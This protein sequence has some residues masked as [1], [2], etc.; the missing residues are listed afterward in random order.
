MFKFTGPTRFQSFTKSVSKYFSNFNL[1]MTGATSQVYPKAYPN[2]YSSAHPNAYTNAYPSAY[3][4]AYP[5]V[6][7]VTMTTQTPW[8]SRMARWT[9]V[10]NQ[11]YSN[12]S[13][14]SRVYVGNPGYY[15]QVRKSQ[16]LTL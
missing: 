9:N 1:G 7:P 11:E 12:G 13:Q 3:P 6:Y 10:R 16:T 15:S 5:D 8:I 14:A 2:A 4:R